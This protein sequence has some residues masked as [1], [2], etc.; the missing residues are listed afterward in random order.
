[1]NEKR[2]IL[3]DEVI[4]D[5]DSVADDGGRELYWT[6]EYIQRQRLVE[7]MNSLNDENEQLK[8]ELQ[9]IYDVATL[10]KTRDIVDKI[11]DDL[12]YETSEK[13]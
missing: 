4:I 9:R 2:F 6:F 5:N 3:E 13:L 10:K 12:L 11:Y 7:L 1:M 8:Q